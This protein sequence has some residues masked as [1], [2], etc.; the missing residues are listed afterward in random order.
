VTLAFET[1]IDYT[2]LILLPSPKLD[3][4]IPSNTN[5]NISIIDF[6]RHLRSKTITSILDSE[7][8]FI[9]GSESE[10]KNNNNQYYL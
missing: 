1:P 5:P 4:D 10:N 3:E 9:M 8:M 7:F 2:V 6:D